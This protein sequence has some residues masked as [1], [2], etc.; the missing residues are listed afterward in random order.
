MPNLR[1]KLPSGNALFVFEAAARCGNFT[2]AAEELYVSQPAV[3]R[4]LSRMEDHL[5]VQLFDRSR[6]SIELTESGKIL[7]KQIAAGFRGIEGAIQEI[8]ARATGLQTVELSVSTAFTTHWLM[9]RMRRFQA[10]F[11][12]VLL[13]FTLIPGRLKGGLGDADLGMRFRLEHETDDHSV[14]VMR[15][16]M[17]PVCSPTYHAQ[18]ERADTVIVM[19][20]GERGWTDRFH[21]FATQRRLVGDILN[22][23]DYA[24]V[25]QAALLGQGVAQGWLNIVSDYL[26][27]GALLP[28]EQEI[29]STT[30]RCCLVWP[31]HRPIRPIVAEIR[32]WI[33][34]E[35]RSDVSRVNARFPA[36]QVSALADRAGAHYIS[37]DHAASADTSRPPRKASGLAIAFSR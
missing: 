26:L 27:Q 33:V 15:E 37:D 29:V 11:P 32:D 35:I 21:A 22:F 1:K 4:M 24:I 23:N 3:S 6:G 5:G 10:A 19:D 36:L 30:R 31:D 20:E 13:R 12:S 7:Y 14:P 16:I 17:L 18:A 2:R 34:D 28:I 9:P 8:E 25:L